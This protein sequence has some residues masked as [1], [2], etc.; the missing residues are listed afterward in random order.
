MK[1]VTIRIQHWKNKHLIHYHIYKLLN[2]RSLLNLLIQC[3]KMI[4]EVL[5]KKFGP[6][7]HVVVGEGFGFE[8][9]YEVRSGKSLLSYVTSASLIEMNRSFQLSL[10]MLD[11][12]EQD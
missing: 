3:A 7:W 8:L 12:L 4:K 11:R 10:N 5:D 1:I 2:Q 6:S 9:S